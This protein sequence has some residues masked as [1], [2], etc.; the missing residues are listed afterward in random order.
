MMDGSDGQHKERERERHTSH[1]TPTGMPTDRYLPVPVGM[2]GTFDL[3]LGIFDEK[4]FCDVILQLFTTVR[5]KISRSP[6]FA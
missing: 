2:R 1:S 4:S 3:L 6:N 5:K